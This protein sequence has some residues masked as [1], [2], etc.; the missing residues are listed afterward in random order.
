MQ[1]RLPRSMLRLLRRHSNVAASLAQYAASALP[2]DLSALLWPLPVHCHQGLRD[3]TIHLP[4]V[5][6]CPNDMMLLIFAPSN[7]FVSVWVLT[8]I[9]TPSFH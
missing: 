7:G 1:I 4:V 2:R 8:D 6:Y 5:L 3:E 9:L